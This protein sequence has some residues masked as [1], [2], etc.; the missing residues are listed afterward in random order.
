[1]DSK[2]DDTQHKAL[3]ASTEAFFAPQAQNS[4]SGIAIIIFVVVWCVLGLSA[5]IAS[6]VCLGRSGTVGAKIAGFLLALFFG[7]FYWIYFLAHSGYC[8]APNASS[9]PPVPA[10]TP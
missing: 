10:P 8:G 5:F 3:G 2:H 4:G 6:I 7:P 1:M 9:A